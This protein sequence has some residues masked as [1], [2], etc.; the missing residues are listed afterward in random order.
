MDLWNSIVP[1]NIDMTK[2]EALQTLKRVNFMKCKKKASKS[3]E[4]LK[5]CL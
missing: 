4:K 2:K 5:L 1:V 3:L